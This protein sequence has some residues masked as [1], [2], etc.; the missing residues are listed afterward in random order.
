[1]PA[2]LWEPLARAAQVA[3]SGRPGCFWARLRCSQPGSQQLCWR[4][5]RGDDDGGAS[6]RP[7]SRR[8]PAAADPQPRPPLPLRARQAQPQEPP[9]Q[10]GL[11]PRRTAAPSR[12]C[13]REWHGDGAL[14]QELSARGSPRLARAFLRSLSP[15]ASLR[16]GCWRRETQRWPRS[17]CALQNRADAC[18]QSHSL[19]RALHC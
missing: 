3:Q 10:T 16:P 17:R 12:A 2:R 11:P 5:Q 9:A 14:A 4:C 18:S 8:T 7:A 19:A 13:A 1:M 15:Q 6:S